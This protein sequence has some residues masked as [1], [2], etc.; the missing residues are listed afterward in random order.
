[1]DTLGLLLELLIIV[2]FLVLKGFF[3]GSEIAMVNCDKLK[4]RH[5]AK[6]GDAGAKLVLKL[7][8][9]PDVILGTTL[10][11][12]NIA[13]VVI[14]TLAA[15]MFINLMG[16]TG[17][18]VSVLVFTPFLLILGEIVPKSIYQQ[19]ANTIAPYII[20][21]L[22]FFSLI[23]YPVIF[24]FSRI[25]RFFTYL[26]GGS[27]SQQSS[28]ITREE[29]RMLLDMSEDSASA[30]KF[31]K[32]RIRRITRFADTTVGEAMIPL[33]EVV[34]IEEDTIMEEAIELV[35][36]N[37]FNR[38][39]VFQGNLTNVVAVLTLDTWDLLEED[40]S[41]KPELTEYTNPPLYISPKQTIDRVL[42]QIQARDDHMAVVVDEFGSAVG[43][44]TMEDIFEEVVGEIDVGYDFEEYKPRRRFEIVQE[45]D[46]SYVVDGRTP[47]SE[48]NDALHIHIPVGGV[49]TVAGF[50]VDRLHL[51]P[52]VESTYDEEDHR[53]T[54]LEADARA[55]TKVHIERIG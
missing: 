13:T 49:H 33:A 6:M 35:F 20:Y 23:F 38:L 37:G 45:E 18:M 32:N 1:M 52:S 30:R 15:V 42:P 40:L 31:N 51:I 47:I 16:S 34:G 22:R 44:L 10:V 4:M 50:M 43:I 27:A 55:V 28:F 25:A 7:F 39:P 8:K 14:S 12:T 5:Q 48:I 21:G 3:S 17:D 2:I 24:I 36:K 46:G 53:F 54:V 26:A 9:T 11:G 29:I 41:S 19:K